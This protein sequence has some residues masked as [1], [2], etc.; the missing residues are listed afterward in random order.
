[1]FRAVPR[2]VPRVLTLHNYRLFCPSGI[3]LRDERPCTDCLDRR[4]VLPS[5]RHGCYRG[6]RLA[7][8]PLALSVAL[9]RAM[10]TWDDHVDAFV[11]LT[12][13][14]R[15]RM[16]EAGLPAARVHVKGNSFAGPALAPG[17]ASRGDYAVFAGRLT[18]EKGVDTL[19][20]AWTAWGA[21]AP[22]LRVL[23]AGRERARLEALARSGPVGRISFLG[24][25]PEAEV[26]RQLAGAKL[27]VVPSRC[28]EGL[29][30]VIPEAFAHATPV[31][32]SSAG[33]LPT[34]VQGGVNGTTFVPDDPSSLLAAL[35]RAWESPGA[36]ERLSAGARATF[37]RSYTEEG[38][39]R[40]LLAIYERAREA[41]SRRAR[42]GSG[43]RLP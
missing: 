4:S 8:A 31:A 34:L 27:V 7:T 10:R 16:V 17:W 3:P 40:A 13:F 1:V 19:V 12:E 36:L 18:S 41:A 20:R 28:F 14:Q 39:H 38:N 32:V 22:E 6:S 2:D 35:R 23:G 24:Q 26:T 5:L 42:G 25:V 15:G 29:P 37:E 30:M 9:H 21:A 43:E 33:P 11:A